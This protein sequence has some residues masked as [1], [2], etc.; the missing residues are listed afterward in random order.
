MLTK[1]IAMTE[2]TPVQMPQRYHWDIVDYCTVDSVPHPTGYWVDADDVEPLVAK[3]NRLRPEVEMLRAALKSVLAACDAG[4]MVER[5]AGVM[6]VEA[7][8]RRSIYLNVPALPI[9]E[10]RAALNGVKD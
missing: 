9:E 8:L 10:A 3:L 5:G 1:E 2:A 7:Q 6:T 4:Y